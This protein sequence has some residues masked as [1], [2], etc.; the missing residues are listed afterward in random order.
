MC[1]LCEFGW[2]LTKMRKCVRK[3]CVAEYCVVCD[4]D[5]LCTECE[6]PF[7]V[8]EGTCELTCPPGWTEDL[9]TL[10]CHG[11]FATAPTDW[12]YRLFAG[13]AGHIFFLCVLCCC[14]GGGY[15]YHRRSNKRYMAEFFE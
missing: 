11:D 6:Y 3:T 13:W 1:S 10:T 5:E 2:L 4:K 12:L 8:L 15:Y 9:K 14:F 7:V